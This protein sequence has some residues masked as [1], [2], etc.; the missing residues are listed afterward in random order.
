[1]GA[2]LGRFGYETIWGHVPQ[3]FTCSE[4]ASEALKC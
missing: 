4:V 2:S 1:M 3:K